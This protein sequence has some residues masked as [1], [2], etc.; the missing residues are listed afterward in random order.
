MLLPCQTQMMQLNLVFSMAV[1]QQ[2]KAMLL[3][4]ASAERQNTRP[5]HYCTCSSE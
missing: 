2:L 5:T 4:R 3:P 1:E